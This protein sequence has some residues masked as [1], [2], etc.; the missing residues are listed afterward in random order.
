MNYKSLLKGC[1]VVA[2]AALICFVMIFSLP[3]ALGQ[4]K[5]AE[6]KPIVIDPDSQELPPKPK[7]IHSH[8]IEGSQ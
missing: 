7:N 2:I 1:H 8:P 3:P 6:T 5:V 4:N